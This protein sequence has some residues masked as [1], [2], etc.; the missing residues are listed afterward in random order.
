[1]K[2]NF[3]LSRFANEFSAF[4]LALIV[5]TLIAGSQTAFGQTRALSLADILIALRSKKA[6]PDEKNKILADAV[7]ERGITF[8]LTSEIEKELDSTGAQTPLIAAIREKNPPKPVVSAVQPVIKAPEPVAKPVPPP[9]DF[10]FYR[11]RA[12]EALKANDFDTAMADLNKAAEL[13]P[14]A[15][16]VYADR[17]L[18]NMRKEQY[19]ASVE[20][21][22]KAVEL[23]PS[24]S[25]SFF[26]IGTIKERQGRTD[27]AITAFERS[28]ALNPND[29]LSKNAAAR[30]T[31]VRSDAL[32]ATEAAAAAKAAPVETKPVAEPT[33]APAVVTLGALNAYAINLAKPAYPSYERRFGGDVTVVAQVTLD[34]EGKITSIKQLEGPK[35]M[36][37]ATETAIKNSTF[38]PVVMADGKPTAAIGTLTY[39]FKG[40]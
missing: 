23:D 9:P 13:K 34:V 4:V 18:I 27:E 17:G 30:L 29:E 1:M 21:F 26:Y 38:K 16:S 14:T 15:A 10:A 11:T 36:W 19:D 33:K 2:R 28:A 25:L 8:T 5:L 12:T 7:K 35:S 37:I 40:Q 24:D 6:L 39:R 20:Q 32:A 3:L 22:N 31:K